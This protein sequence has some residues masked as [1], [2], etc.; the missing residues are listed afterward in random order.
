VT[1]TYN[2]TICDDQIK[3]HRIC[4]F[5]LA[6]SHCG[7]IAINQQ[8]ANCFYLKA[9]KKYVRDQYWSCS[10]RA[11]AF[12][13]FS[14]YLSCQPSDTQRANDFSFADSVQLSCPTANSPVDAASRLITFSPESAIGGPRR[15]QRGVRYF[16]SWYLHDPLTW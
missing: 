3:S 12:G 14:T 11:T 9:Q 2:N 6:F 4:E 5:S 1:C 13:H 15:A 7:N 10:C 8:Q 16:N